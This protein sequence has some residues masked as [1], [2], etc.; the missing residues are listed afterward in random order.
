MKMFVDSDSKGEGG[1][2]H[3][4]SV[5]AGAAL[6]AAVVPVSAVLALALSGGVRRDLAA[7]FV[8][9]A[10]V[11]DVERRLGFGWMAGFALVMAGQAAGA[12]AGP[13]SMFDPMG[14][15]AHTLFGL[16]GEVVMAAVTILV[17]RRD[18][19]ALSAR[20]DG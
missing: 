15:L 13:M 18:R 7:R 9:A 1:R 17:V 4:A 11:S 19:F 20:V 2:L 6:A 12:A 10:R 16:C 5:L 3:N 8:P 14:L